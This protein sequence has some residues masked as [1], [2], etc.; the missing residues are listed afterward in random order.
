M[1]RGVRCT[2]VIEWNSL[3]DAGALYL[4][5]KSAPEQD[6]PTALSH[7]APR[8]VVRRLDAGSRTR[9][10][11]RGFSPVSDWRSILGMGGAFGMMALIVQSRRRLAQ[12]PGAVACAASLRGRCRRGCRAWVGC[13][14]RASRHGSPQLH[15]PLRSGPPVEL[16][17]KIGWIE[18][19]RASYP[20]ISDVSEAI[21]WWQCFSEPDPKLTAHQLCDLA[22]EHANLQSKQSVKTGR[23]APCPCGSGKKYKKCCGA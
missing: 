7:H 20:P 10:S 6:V 23:N 8:A 5:K 9:G 17:K 3:A 4:L 22:R 2:G 11:T 16:W 21:S 18:R 19:H 13:S 12:H 1:P 14:P 15:E